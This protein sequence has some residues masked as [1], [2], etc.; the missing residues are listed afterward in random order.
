[1]TADDVR[2]CFRGDVYGEA[3]TMTA[4]WFADHVARHDIDLERSPRWTVEGE[5]AAIALLAFR[6]E[7]AWIGGFGVAPAFRGHGV[8][9]ICVGDVLG[10]ARDAGAATI[11][12]EVLENNSGAIRL[13]ERGGFEQIDEL[14]VWRRERLSVRREAG[15]ALSDAPRDAIAVAAIAR[16]PATCWQ[17]EPRSIA[18]AAPFVTLTIEDDAAYAFVRTAGPHGVALLD[19]GARDDASASALCSFLD[20]SFAEHDLTLLNE[21]SQGGLHE[22]L[23]GEPFWDQI[24]RQRRM[25]IALR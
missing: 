2:A 17:R 19:A 18:A 14:I 8:G 22:A 24:F 6:G 25:R 23:T 11:E 5:L 7:R 16:S 15:G 21:P 1:V 13:Y 20:A 9:G 12:L 3:E 4:A 10:I